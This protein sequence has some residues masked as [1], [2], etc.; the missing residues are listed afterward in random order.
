MCAGLGLLTLFAGFYVNGLIKNYKQNISAPSID[1]EFKNSDDKNSGNALAW[2]EKGY[3]LMEIGKHKEATEAFNKAKLL[4]DDCF[5]AQHYLKIG[6]WYYKI[7][8]YE[9]AEMQLRKAISMNSENVMAHIKLAD[10][11]VKL[12]KYSESEVEYREALKLKPDFALTH[13]LIANLLVEL[14]RNNEAEE[15]YRRAIKIQPYLTVARYN[16]LKLLNKMGRDEEAAKEIDEIEKIQPDYKSAHYD[17]DDFLKD[18]EGYSE[19]EK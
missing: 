18:I 5:D 7:N 11:L 3:E 6:T 19:D 2:L 13:F 1:K 10:T 9:D 8:R 4:K 12:K 17:I 14:K 16:L 15:E